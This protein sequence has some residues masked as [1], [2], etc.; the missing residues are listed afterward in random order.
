MTLVIVCTG[1]LQYF[2]EK[3]YMKLAQSFATELEY[4]A[5]ITIK[6]LERVPLDRFDWAPHEKS[7]SIGQLANHIAEMPAWIPI[8]LN[9]TELDFDQ[10]KFTRW[11][12]RDNTALINAFTAAV[13]EANK[14]FLATSNEAFM[15]LWTLRRGEH[16]TF[17]LPKAAV[18]RNNCLNH[19][20]HHRAQLSVYLR[21]MDIP[22]P[23]AYGPSA[24]E[25][26]AG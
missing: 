6:F 23:G 16:I 2:S 3:P 13:Q 14:L 12:Y 5:G 7:M 10:F 17:T 24:D 21:L 20:Y 22:V 18:I 26:R 15:D 9:S 4:E 11:N 19:L 8:T 25:K 1:T